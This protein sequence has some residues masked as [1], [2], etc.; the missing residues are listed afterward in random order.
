MKSKNGITGQA[1]SYIARGSHLILKVIVSLEI[2]ELA[3]RGEILS[4]HKLRIY[5]LIPHLKESSVALVLKAV[6][7]PG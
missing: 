3:T 4:R 6:F 2:Q 1:F 7:S 5:I